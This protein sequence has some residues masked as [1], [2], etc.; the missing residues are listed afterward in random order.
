MY[1]TYQGVL[2]ILWSVLCNTGFICSI[3]AASLRSLR[4]EKYMEIAE[5]GPAVR[6]MIC[7]GHR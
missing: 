3:N 4:I 2:L 6:L 1:P 5:I 7:H